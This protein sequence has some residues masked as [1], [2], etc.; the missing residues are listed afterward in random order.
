[1][2]ARRTSF[3]EGGRFGSYFVPNIAF[4]SL[5]IPTQTFFVPLPERDLFEKTFELINSNADG[6]VNSIVAIAISTTNTI[7]KSTCSEQGLPYC[8]TFVYI[9]VILFLTFL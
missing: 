1:M 5:Q 9:F 4:P 6:N 8:D 7:G 3:S 2:F